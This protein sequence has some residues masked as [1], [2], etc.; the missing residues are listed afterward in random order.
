MKD[1][2]PDL[3]IK[4]VE[5]KDFDWI[6]QSKSF[7]LWNMKVYPGFENVIFQ[8]LPQRIDLESYGLTKVYKFWM[9]TSTRIITWKVI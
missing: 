8:D 1:Y 2:K 5:T 3:K 4:S 7:V 6:I 9:E